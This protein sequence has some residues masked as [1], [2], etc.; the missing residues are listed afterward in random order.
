MPYDP[1]TDSLNE[2]YS[3]NSMIA[4]LEADLR[5]RR[6]T[7]AMQQTRTEE[8][9]V[10]AA[11]IDC[12]LAQ[13]ELIA[14]DYNN[15]LITMV[16]AT[17]FISQLAKKPIAIIRASDHDKSLRGLMTREIK[18]YGYCDYA[19]KRGDDNAKSFK[20]YEDWLN[21]LDDDDFLASFVRTKDRADNL[22]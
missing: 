22:D 1:K 16:S 13:R 17:S 11:R 15:A 12:M 9:N 21:S 10:E 2:L 6:S 7:L 5:N 3:D 18:D 19:F 4:K 20:S 14:G 8:E